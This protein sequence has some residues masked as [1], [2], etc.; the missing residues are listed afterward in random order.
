M[1]TSQ[2]QFFFIWNPVSRVPSFEY[3]IDMIKWEWGSSHQQVSIVDNT[4]F[5]LTETLWDNWHRSSCF[6]T[7]LWPRIDVNPNTRGT[8]YVL[9]LRQ[10][11][12]V[13]TLLFALHQTNF[14]IL[15]TKNP[16][17]SVQPS[18]FHA[19]KCPV[20]VKG[21]LPAV[22]TFR[23]GISKLWCIMNN[24][25]ENLSGVL[26]KLKT[27]FWRSISVQS[28]YFQVVQTVHVSSKNDGRQRPLCSN[29]NNRY[30]RRHPW[31]RVLD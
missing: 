3:W 15:L 10:T 31:G 30:P 9:Q 28:H 7:L 22:L 27:L 4:Q 23:E 26:S 1:N 24:A 5:K 8:H 18:S 20:R 12:D 14:V 16:L 17:D 25:R 2:R 13:N 29:G 21:L 11:N 19:T 6:L